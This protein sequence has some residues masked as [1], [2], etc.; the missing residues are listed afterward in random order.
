MDSI[1]IKDKYGNTTLSKYTQ[2]D[3]NQILLGFA[4]KYNIKVIATNDAHYID[5]EDYEAHDILLCI[6]TGNKLSDENRFRFSGS[7]YYFKTKKEMN[8]LFKDVPHAL[9]NTMEIASKIEALDLSRK[10]VLPEFPYPDKFSSQDDYLRHLTF[11]GAQRKYGSISPELEERIN[12]ELSVIASSGYPG[13]FL[14]VQDL[15]RAARDMG[16]FVGPGRGSAAGS[17]VAYALD[18]T[19]VDPL[20]YQLLFER[21]LNPERISMP[22]IDID[23][24]DEG[25]SKVVDYVIEK[26]GQSQVAQIITYGTM[27]AKLSIKDV[28]RVMD[29][30][31]DTVNRITKQYPTNLGASL[32]KVLKSGGIDKELEAAMTKDDVNKAYE[33]RKLAAEKSEVGKMIQLAKV[34]EGNIRNT[35]IHA[36]G[37]I[38][39]PDDIT[40]YVP[41]STSKDNNMLV[42]QFDNSVVEDSGLLKMDFLGLRNLS[43]IRDAQQMVKENHGVD[44]D[45]DNLPLDD[46][47]T[48]EI[49]QQWNTKGKFQFES[50]GMATSLRQLKP[51]RFEDLI[52]MTALY[53]PGPMAYIKD[54]VERKHGRDKI[55]YDLQE[56][57]EYLKETYGITVYQEQVML[58]SQKLAGFTKGEADMLRKGMGKK[59]KDVIDALYEKF[60]AGCEKNGHPKRVYDKIW[61][62]WEKF[63]S[64]AFNKSHA[65]CY[66][67]ISWQTAYLKANYP[68]EYMASLLNHNSSNIKSLDFYL[69]E[70]RFMNLDVLGPSINESRARFHVTSKGVIRFGLEGIKGVG[71][72]PVEEII[73]VREK[74]IVFQ[75]H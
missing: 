37:I 72:G 23:F 38:I 42:S 53:R 12:F 21:F 17:V 24:D 50:E 66:A 10:I 68:A 18:I 4:S 33:F 9:D 31:L 69:S 25:R 3:I 46:E 57:E 22:D 54:F 48:R 11:A 15:I 62:D 34:L 75:S 20:H 65:A 6:N 44:I 28:G 51:T 52:A 35:G 58:L 47:K 29:V 30:P 63:A 70:C 1:R 71:S 8:T 19:N 67:I 43:I 14:I 61:K 56:M 55:E 73:K 36:C 74:G 32:Q 13:Y 59:K 45:I 39:T 7:D 26:Y 40:E 5:K 41:V 64:Y 2:E 27:A 16:V 60:S 49:F